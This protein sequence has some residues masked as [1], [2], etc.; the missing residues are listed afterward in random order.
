MDD[1]LKKYP[2][3]KKEKIIHFSH[4]EYSMD[5]HGYFVREIQSK[6]EWLVNHAHY[7]KFHVVKIVTGKGTGVINK[8]VKK[9]L[10]NLKKKKIILDWKDN[11]I[12]SILI[13]F[14]L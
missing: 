2:V 9:I 4:P 12:G 3:P 5:L 11:D 7:N 8:E 6:I 1:L 14:K 13:K 10:N